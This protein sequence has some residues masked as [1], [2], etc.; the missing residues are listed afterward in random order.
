MRLVLISDT[1]SRHDFKIPEGDTLLHAGDL[2]FT[3][4]LSEISREA[5]WLKE[6]KSGLGFKNIIVVPGNHD[7]MADDDPA[8]IRSLFEEAGCIYLQHQ[9]CTI[10]GLN[11][12]GSGYTPEFGQGWA[13]NVPRGDKLAALWSQIPEETNVLITHG[14]PRGRL[15]EC[16]RSDSS[17]WGTLYGDDMRYIIE[18]VGCWDL[19]NRISNLKQLRLHVFGHIHHKY[20]IETGADGIIY[21]NASICD[22]SYTAK[23]APHVVDLDPK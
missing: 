20:G 19:A 5:Q 21:A 17:G 3:G 4:S 14:P 1:H 18:H 15:D 7:L 9:P 22:P 13:M 8:M 23:N 10:D 2:T 11:F 6:V 12:F 16:R